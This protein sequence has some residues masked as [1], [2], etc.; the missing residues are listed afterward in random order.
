ME[1]DGVYGGLPNTTLRFSGA[2]NDAKYKE[3]K[4]SSQV[5]PSRVRRNIRSIS[6]R[7][8]AFQSGVTSSI[9]ARTGRTEASSTLITRSRATAGFPRP[10]WWIWRSAWA[11][12][13]ANTTSASWRRTCSMTTRR[14]RGPGT[15]SRQRLRAVLVNAST[16]L[17]MMP[18][19]SECDDS[20]HG[21][22]S[23]TFQ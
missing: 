9:R 12:R 5:R 8:I 14:S 7:T 11:P 17:W 2:Y 23:C 16:T 22:R 13:T 10:A 15:R 3:F 6:A 4:F 20:L 18:I 19:A 1:I 21:A